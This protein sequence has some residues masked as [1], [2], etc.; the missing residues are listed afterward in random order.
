MEENRSGKSD[1]RD[2]LETSSRFF[3]ERGGGLDEAPNH[4]GDQPPDPGNRQCPGFGDWFMRA[5]R[6]RVGVHLLN[7]HH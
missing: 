3:A 7:G 4:P 6:G 5:G 2:E 1:P